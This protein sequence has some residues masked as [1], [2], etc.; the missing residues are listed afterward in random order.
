MNSRSSKKHK[1]LVTPENDLISIVSTRYNLVENSTVINGIRN[2][3]DELKISYF[4]NDE[5]SYCYPN[6]MKYTILFPDL[7][8]RDNTDKG[9][10]LG[11]SVFNSYDAQSPVKFDWMMYRYI[12][13]NGSKTI[14]PIKNI[15][16]RHY[17]DLELSEV[18]SIFTDAQIKIES[19]ENKIRTLQTVETI[20]HLLIEDMR[21]KF[22][23]M[24]DRIM[25][26]SPPDNLWDLYNMFTY[27]ISHHVKPRSQEMYLQYLNQ[28]FNKHI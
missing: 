17:K 25:L 22:P 7:H 1:A 4:Y 18:F 14:V 8:V 12:C 9:M 2:S 21:R 15:T 27:Y 3:L 16:M 13:Q 28:T 11:L 20:P 23:Q 5:M 10:S 24:I 6:K 19:I 26:Q